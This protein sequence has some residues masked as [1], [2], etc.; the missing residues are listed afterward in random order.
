M[1]T[2]FALLTVALTGCSTSDLVYYINDVPIYPEFEWVE[3]LI[4]QD[5]LNTCRHQP[6]CSVDQLFNRY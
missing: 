1:K 4:F 6:T 3:P 5:N 2:V